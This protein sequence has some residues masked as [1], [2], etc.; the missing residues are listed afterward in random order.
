MPT[1]RGSSV[2]VSILNFT[3]GDASSSAPA[4]TNPSASQATAGRRRG[5]P[6]VELDWATHVSRLA[7]LKLEGAPPCG[8][9][10]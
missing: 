4:W 9:R 5:G 10:G 3:S 1:S 7:A 8:A 2:S 6:G